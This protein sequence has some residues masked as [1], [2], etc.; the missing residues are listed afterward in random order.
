MAGSIFFMLA[1]QNIWDAPRGAPFRWAPICQQSQGFPRPQITQA[2][3]W[4]WWA[5]VRY[6]LSH[7]WDTSLSFNQEGNFYHL[8]TIS[9]PLW[10]SLQTPAWFYVDN[11]L[12]SQKQL[13]QLAT[14]VTRAASSKGSGW[15]DWRQESVLLTVRREVRVGDAFNTTKS[16]VLQCTV[17]LIQASFT[18]P[19]LFALKATCL[20]I[21]RQ[22]L[23][24]NNLA[25]CV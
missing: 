4:L 2:L 22:V 6:N 24:W 8:M 18:W 3:G 25:K 19:V 5:L 9:W 13:S 17:L 23:H 10:M 21:S 7:C 20:Y 12:S 15:M 14:V 11:C 1:L 16:A